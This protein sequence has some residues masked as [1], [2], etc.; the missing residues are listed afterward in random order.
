M[1]PT[2]EPYAIAKWAGLSLCAS[3][4]RQYGTRYI[5][6]IPC[7]VYGPADNFDLGGAHVLSA[8]IRKF[9]EGK[10]RGDRDVTLWGTGE[11]RREFLYADDLAEACEQLLNVYE[12]DEPVNIGSGTSHAIRDIAALIAEIVGFH[13]RIR[14]DASQPDGAPE[15]CLDSSAIRDLGWA[16][17][18]TLR[19]G[20]ARTYH[21][22]LEHEVSQDAS[23]ASS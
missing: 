10:E 21:W 14:W 9:H 8:L 20:L 7:T 11:A 13:G 17:R 16:P 4:N 12:G 19:D 18:T 23:C 5:T 6:A 3:Y 22:F 1:E 15:K 2:S